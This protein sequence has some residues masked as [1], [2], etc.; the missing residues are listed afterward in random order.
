MRF[1]LWSICRSLSVPVSL[2]LALSGCL[3]SSQSQLDEERE[4]H[5][6][7]GMGLVNAM[8]YPGAIES[9]EKAID[10]NPRSASAHFQ[11]G[12]LFEQKDPDPA[13][14]IYHYSRYLRLRPKAENAEI[15]KQRIS[16]CKQELART[17]S[18]GPVTEKVQRELEQLAEDKRRLTEEN[19]QLSDELAKWRAGGA[20]RPATTNYSGF[21]G[22]STRPGGLAPPPLNPA[23]SNTTNL[24]QTPGTGSPRTHKVK[25]GENPTLI[26]R[27]YG[28]RLDA[29]LAAN[30][31]LDPRRIQVGQTLNIPGR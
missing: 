16:G 31:Q 26:A 5:Y 1:W 30:P 8:D 19:K 22:R 28:I 18:L 15:V 17:V 11:L 2:A 27:Q 9:F 7:A 20:G 29:L 21:P 25:A 12:W 23:G 24:V 4:P 13:A 3:P 6:L 14:A 10:V